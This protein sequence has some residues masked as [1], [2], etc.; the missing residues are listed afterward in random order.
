M[1]YQILTATSPQELEK[2]VNQ[3]IEQGLQ[4]HGD[5]Q[6]SRVFVAGTPTTQQHIN[7]LYAQ[8]VM[9]PTKKK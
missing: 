9:E 3:A 1:K 4:P 5:L 8:A 7:S 6:V 2:Q